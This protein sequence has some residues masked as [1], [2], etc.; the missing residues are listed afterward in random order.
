MEHGQQVLLEQGKETRNAGPE[1]VTGR[2]TMASPRIVTRPRRKLLVTW[3][4]G[5]DST[6]GLVR[7]LRETDDEVFV[8]HIHRFAPHDGKSTAAQSC[9]YE[10]VAITRMLPV[11]RARYRDFTYSESLVDNTLFPQFAPDA[12][13]VMLLAA[14]AAKRSGFRPDDRILD[15]MN[16]DEDGHWA[17]GSISGRLLYMNTR[18][19]LKLVLR[20]DLV[21]DLYTYDGIP[22]KAE[23][24]AYLPEDLVQMNASCRAPQWLDGIWRSCGVC[25]KCRSFAGMGLKLPTDPEDGQ[26]LRELDDEARPTEP[27]R[28]VEVRPVGA[29][30][31][32]VM[33]SGG[34]KST[35]ALVRL[36]EQTDEQVHVHHIL[37]SESIDRR[38][39]EHSIGGH[40]LSETKAKLNEI[41]RLYRPFKATMSAVGPDRMVGHTHTM[42]IVAYFAAQAALSW[43][44]LPIDLVVLGAWGAAANDD[45]PRPALYR[46]GEVL[47]PQMLKAIMRSEDG[48][49]FVLG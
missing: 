46:S 30:K 24:V 26:K 11:I 12:T 34:E 43:R 45:D 2:S 4:G 1:P 21:P 6:Y 42:N 29:R 37:C 18:H 20:S 15:V 35:A 9:A 3:S 49:Q 28:D 5:L 10:A 40:L 48:P 14:C 7:V 16:K 19:I 38:P 22:T 36:L 47:A 27:K 32:L 31:H 44:M 23:E 41:R 17:P 8:H 33:W 39:A 13:T 25:R